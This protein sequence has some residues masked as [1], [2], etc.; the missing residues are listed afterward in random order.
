MI[1]EIFF[2]LFKILITNL[3]NKNVIFYFKKY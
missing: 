2:S 1:M 3:K